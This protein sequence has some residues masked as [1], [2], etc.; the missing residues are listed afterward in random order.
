MYFYFAASEAEDEHP[1]DKQFNPPPNLSY[2]ERVSLVELWMNGR[3]SGSEGEWRRE[4][5]RG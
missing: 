5:R 1:E 2:H 3:D 4:A